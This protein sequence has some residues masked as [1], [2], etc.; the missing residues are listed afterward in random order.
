MTI[1]QPFTLT[2]IGTTAGSGIV[3]S[4]IQLS[5]NPCG[6]AAASCTFTGGL[7]AVMQAGVTK[8]FGIVSGAFLLGPAMRQATSFHAVLDNGGSMTLTT[9]SW[10]GSGHIHGSGSATVHL[11]PEPGTLGL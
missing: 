4:G 3:I 2:L 6:P 11:I 7:L 5:P 8:D 10:N 1:F 9:F